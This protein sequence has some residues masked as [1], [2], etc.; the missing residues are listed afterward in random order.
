MGQH[1]VA[2]TVSGTTGNV[3]G[4]E[5]EPHTE[6][7]AASTTDRGGKK[8]DTLS[9]RITEKKHFFQRIMDTFFKKLKLKT[10]QRLK[11]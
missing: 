11:I 5:T 1:Y 10:G 4:E 9:N 6:T 3:V 2:G 8:R 7:T